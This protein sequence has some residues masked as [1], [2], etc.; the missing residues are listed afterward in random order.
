MP[1]AILIVEDNQA[2]RQ[3]LEKLLADNGY[4]VTTAATG[5]QAL[6]AVKRSKPDAILMDINMPEMDGFA[7]TR[8]LLRGEADTRDIPVIVVSAKDQKADKAWAQML[9]VKGYITK[10]FTDEQ[11]L[12]QVRAV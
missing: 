6:D 7:A 3:R 4:A 5:V 11:V 8:A 2:E 10:P 12:S 1:R 9:G